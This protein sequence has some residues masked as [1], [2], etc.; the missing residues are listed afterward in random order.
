MD[1]GV[2]WLVVWMIIGLLVAAALIVGVNVVPGYHLSSGVV[3]GTVGTAAVA[4][5]GLL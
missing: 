2:N 1:R 5:T 4:A 3:G